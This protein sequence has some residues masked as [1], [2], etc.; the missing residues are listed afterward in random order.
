VRHNLLDQLQ[1]LEHGCIREISPQ[2]YTEVGKLRWA[3]ARGTAAECP[4]RVAGAALR[5]GQAFDEGAHL[6]FLQAEKGR[7]TPDLVLHIRHDQQ[8]DQCM[9]IMTYIAR[10]GNEWIKE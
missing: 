9:T 7:A 10:S 8:E 3:C 2:P 6:G 5:T 1:A 4:T